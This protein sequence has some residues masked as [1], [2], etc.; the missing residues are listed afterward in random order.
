VIGSRAGGDFAVVHGMHPMRG[1]PV[2][3]RI[4]PL[5]GRRP[6]AFLVESADG[7]IDDDEVWRWAAKESYVLSAEGTRDLVARIARR[8]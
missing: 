7:A 4:R 2:T 6:A 1:Y 5:Q 8:V 3:C